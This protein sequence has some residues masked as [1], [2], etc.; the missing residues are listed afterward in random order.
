MKSNKQNK[1]TLN[2]QRELKADL[3][4]GKVLMNHTYGFVYLD[5]KG[6]QVKINVGKHRRNKDYNFSSPNLWRVCTKW[7]SFLVKTGLY[8]LIKIKYWNNFWNKLS[9]FPY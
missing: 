7:E 5:K 6:N 2:R 9:K 8:K 3:I 1:Y 4:L